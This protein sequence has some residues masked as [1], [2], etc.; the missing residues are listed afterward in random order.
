MKVTIVSSTVKAVIGALQA[1]AAA[2]KKW[3]TATDLLVADGVTSAMLASKGGDADLRE[4]VK[5]Q[6][7][8]ASF[9]AADQA[10]MEKETK[11]LND[12]QKAAKR[13]VQMKVG[14]YYARIEGYLRKAEDKIRIAE[15]SDAEL[16][17]EA[18]KQASIK[19]RLD[20]DLASWIVRLEKCEANDFKSLPD[21]IKA[22]KIAQTV[23]NAA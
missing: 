23:C 12:N 22:L 3:I 5:T 13:A 15:M 19:A 2:D 7:V 1:T 17:E 10:L 6:I 20:K 8:V 16:K 14:A 18:A 21:V 9:K 11:S 4:F